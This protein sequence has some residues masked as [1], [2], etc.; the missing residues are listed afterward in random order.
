M[1][2]CFTWI[3]GSIIGFFTGGVAMVMVLYLILITL[4]AIYSTIED[5]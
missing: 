3:F 1:K 5:L 2:L 4:N